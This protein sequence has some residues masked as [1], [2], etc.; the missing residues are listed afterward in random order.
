MEKGTTF[1]DL[2]VHKEAIDLAM[3]L[4]GE[5]RPVEWQTSDEVAAIR[6]LVRKLQRSA[7]RASWSLRLRP[8]ASRASGSRR[9]VVTRASSRSCCAQGY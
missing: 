2:D 5:T 8:R 6:R 3:L 1:V 4:P 7:C 9:T